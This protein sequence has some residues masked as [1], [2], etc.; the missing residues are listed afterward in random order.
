MLRDFTIR[1]N[2]AFTRD[3]R[4]DIKPEA[5]RVVGGRPLPYK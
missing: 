4:S 5:V 3:S 2:H 1:D